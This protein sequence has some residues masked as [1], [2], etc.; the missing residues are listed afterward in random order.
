MKPGRAMTALAAGAALIWGTAFAAPDLPE[1]QQEIPII[2]LEM[3]PSQPGAPEAS[4]QE[5]AL[6]ALLLLQLLMNMQAVEASG[7]ETPVVAPVAD[8]QQRI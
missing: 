7:P 4:E 3:Q 8:G 5:Q 2:I 6:A 1:A